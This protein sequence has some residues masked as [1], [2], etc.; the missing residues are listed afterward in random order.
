MAKNQDF[1]KKEEKKELQ[2]RFGL[3]SNEIIVSKKASMNSSPEY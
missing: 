3:K 2:E 1:E